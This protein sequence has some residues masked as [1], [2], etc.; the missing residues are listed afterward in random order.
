MFHRNGNIV[1]GAPFQGGRKSGQVQVLAVMSAAVSP[2]W[3]A[4]I[5]H[6]AIAAR[7][8]AVMGTPSVMV[9]R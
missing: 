8:T 3:S 1:T 4:L 5:V 2:V 7:A 6:A 9:G